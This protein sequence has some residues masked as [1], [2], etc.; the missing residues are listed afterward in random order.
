L[1]ED[2]GIGGPAGLWLG[3]KT[4]SWHGDAGRKIKK[5]QQVVKKFWTEIDDRLQRNSF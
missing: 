3:Q 1:E 5:N 4:P 2:N